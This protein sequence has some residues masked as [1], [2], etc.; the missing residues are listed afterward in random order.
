[1]DNLEALARAALERD[2]MATRSILQDILRNQTLTLVLQ[3]PDSDDQRLM[4]MAAG[5]A[6]LL[7]LRQ[8]QPPPAWTKNVG[9]LKEPF[10]LLEA[11]Q[12]MK[13]LRELCETQSP[14]PLRKRGLY[15]PPNFLESA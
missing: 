1:M 8:N 10:Y 4:V 2:S 3:Q 5:L 12:S 14:E 11:A 7:A 9:A 13:R 6:E 15:A